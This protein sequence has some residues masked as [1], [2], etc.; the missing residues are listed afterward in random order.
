MYCGVKVKNIAKFT[1]DS[2]LHNTEE[3]TVEEEFF[4]TILTYLLCPTKSA[5]EQE[6]NILK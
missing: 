2:I 1:K 3:R 5:L 4:K 6:N